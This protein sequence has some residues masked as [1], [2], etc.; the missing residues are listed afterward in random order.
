[1][2][3]SSIKVMLVDDHA[4]VREGYRRLIEKHEDMTVVAE[5]ADGAEAYQE[6]KQYKPD[7]VVLDL[8]M[9]GKGE[10]K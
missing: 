4:V 10:L 3:A 7:V 2:S 8:S 9:P 6:Y 1:M 5:A